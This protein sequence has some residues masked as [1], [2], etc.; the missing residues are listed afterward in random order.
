MGHRALVTNRQTGLD[1]RATRPDNWSMNQSVLFLCTA[2]Y[3]RSRFAEMLFNHL[4]PQK[5]LRERAASRGLAVE[6][7]LRVN[8]GPISTHTLQ[9]L[10]ARRIPT[11]Q[12]PRMPIQASEADFRKARC[13]IALHEPEH[14]PMMVALFP[15]WADRIEYWNVADIG[16]VSPDIALAAIEAR[17]SALLDSLAP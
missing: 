11:G 10:A 12:P 5:G 2:N 16:D 14:R 6:L 17:V 1:Q 7:G 3:Y 4:A 13:A 9:G 8:I 15:V